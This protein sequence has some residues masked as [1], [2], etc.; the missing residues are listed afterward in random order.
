MSITLQCA[1]AIAIFQQVATLSHNSS[2]L[3]QIQTNALPSLTN[4]WQRI[5]FQN[6][7]FQFITI[8][9]MV[10]IFLLCVY[11]CFNM[12]YFFVD[13]FPSLFIYIYRVSLVHEHIN[14]Q[15]D[16]KVN[17]ALFLFF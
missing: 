10:L 17:V 6:Y 12:P 5:P 13:G 1:Q 3:P 14:T 8:I 16:R 15:S 11:I 4:L 7:V 9:L 2:F